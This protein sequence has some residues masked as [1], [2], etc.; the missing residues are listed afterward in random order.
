MTA[1]ADS[2][3]STSLATEPAGVSSCLHGRPIY[4]ESSLACDSGDRHDPGQ[5]PQGIPAVEY[6]HEV[7]NLAERELA[8]LMA[9]M[10]FALPG[11]WRGPALIHLPSGNL[12]YQIVTS[13]GGPLDPVPV[14]TYNSMASQTN[15]GFGY[16]VSDLFNPTIEVTG[17]NQANLTTGSGKCLVYS[18]MELESWATAPTGARNALMRKYDLTWVEHQ[19]DG[20][21]WHYNAGGCLEKITTPEG[22]T[23]TVARSGSSVTITGPTGR[24]V[25]YNPS[26]VNQ[27]GSRDTVFEITQGLLTKVTYPDGGELILGYSGKLLTQISEPEAGSASYEYDLLERVT[28][29]TTPEGHD[30][31]LSYDEEEDA[32]GQKTYWI[33][34]T[35]PAGKV[36]TV[37][38]DCHVIESVIN[39]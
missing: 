21:Q 5:R 29:I 9:R 7:L 22:R 39:P 34:I 18:D 4:P 6:D 10:R 12:V 35:D 38:H 3:Q 15:I 25:T 24:V 17:S 8:N 23:W 32:F 20:L 36:T 19:P 13:K 14:F 16:G 2:S 27:P 31:E 28:R 33:E 1:G 37:I 30:Y 11:V 26:G